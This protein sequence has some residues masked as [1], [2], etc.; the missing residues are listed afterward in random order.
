MDKNKIIE[1]AYETIK[2]S[3]EWGIVNEGKEYGNWIDGVVAMTDAL[4]NEIDKKDC[5]SIAD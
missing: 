1:V 3:T 4:I 2:E 5:E